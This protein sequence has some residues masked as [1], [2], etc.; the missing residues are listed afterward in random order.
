MTDPAPSSP[1]VAPAAAPAPL[2]TTQATLPT[3]GAVVGTALG[4]LVSAKLGF[5][6]PLLGDTITTIV[7]GAVTAAFHWAGTKFGAIKL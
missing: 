2:S 4:R 5:T 3:L 7:A 1:P 6:D